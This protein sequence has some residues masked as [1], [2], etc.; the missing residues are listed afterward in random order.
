MAILS[1]QVIS[2]RNLLFSAA[3]AATPGRE[4]LV[5]ISIDLEMARNYPTWDQT[6]WDYEKGNLSEPV[7]KYALAA[8]RRVK[9]RGG[10]I[11]FFAVGR[12]FEQENVG[13]LEEIVRLGHPV[14]NHTYDH[15]NIRANETTALQ[16]RFRRA[17][18][19]IAGKT[20]LEVIGENIRMTTAAMKARLGIEPAG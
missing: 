10:L 2:R 6:E 9:E 17:S 1:P 12:V 13:W 18:W 11:H 7:K 20:P 16:P 3:A 15:V 19:L 8:A 4:A 14:G 5:S